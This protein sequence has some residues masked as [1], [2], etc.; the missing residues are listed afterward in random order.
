MSRV[1]FV[2]TAL[3]LVA[4]SLESGDG[5]QLESQ[6]LAL[7]QD[8]TEPE[9]LLKVDDEQRMVWGWASISKEHGQESIDQ[10]GDYVPVHELQKA[11]HEKFIRER[12]GKTMHK[13]RKTHEI[14]DS[15]VFTKELQKA[16]GID[17]PYEGW[18][19]G[20]KVHDDQTWNLVKSGKY[21]S[22]S[23]GGTGERHPLSKLGVEA[24]GE[25]D[26]EP[27]PTQL[28]PFLARLAKYNHHHDQARQVLGH[29]RWRRRRR[30]RGK[31]TS[32][33]PYRVH[34]ER[35]QAHLLP[36]RLRPQGALGAPGGGGGG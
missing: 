33:R 9:L 21:R 34:V 5:D 4:K 35:H 17:L 31:Q 19:V 7:A 12:V 32:R 20:V 15:I 22:F 10:Q 36:W 25:Q 2:E 6:L 28:S 18:F 3:E 13:G 29:R 14:V 23:I 27:S 1:A 26:G 11:V 8:Y 30:R 24:V 16:L